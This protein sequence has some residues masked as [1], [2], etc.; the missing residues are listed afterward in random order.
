MAHIL[1]KH[2][3]KVADVDPGIDL[4]SDSKVSLNTRSS[5][6]R[7]RQSCKAE[8]AAV[9]DSPPE[10]SRFSTGDDFDKSSL[11]LETLFTEKLAASGA[12]S[13]A[14]EPSFESPA[15]WSNGLCGCPGGSGGIT[16]N[17]ITERDAVLVARNVVAS[18]PITRTRAIRISVGEPAAK[19]RKIG[20]ASLFSTN[21]VLGNWLPCT[22]VQISVLFLIRTPNQ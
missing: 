16:L 21:R 8:K 22:S 11:A 4:D 5:R 18:T 15:S 19:K 9:A 20:K 2:V 3:E 12:N 14:Q 13:P 10:D 1:E 17:L 6:A 7:R